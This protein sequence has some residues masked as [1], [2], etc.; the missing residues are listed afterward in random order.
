[1]RRCV[2]EGISLYLFLPDEEVRNPTWDELKQIA[3]E[4]YVTALSDVLDA[5]DGSP[6]FLADAISDDGR[7]MVPNDNIEEFA[8]LLEKAQEALA[9]IKSPDKK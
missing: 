2:D 5:L 9:N 6:E 1:M 8:E 3:A 7:F 4:A